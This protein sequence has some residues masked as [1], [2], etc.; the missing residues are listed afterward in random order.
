M[1]FLPLSKLKKGGC[2]NREIFIPIRDNNKNRG[3]ESL[4]YPF[5][6]VGVF[7]KGIKKRKSQKKNTKLKSLLC[8][9]ALKNFLK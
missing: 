1:F 3:T 7:N 6:E 9:L 4:L 5:F 2:P 8:T